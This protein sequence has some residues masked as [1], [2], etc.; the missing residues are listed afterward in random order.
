MQCTLHYPE[1]SYSIAKV[2]QKR[3]D[4]YIS[5]M[6]SVRDESLKKKM[7]QFFREFALIP[8]PIGDSQPCF[9]LAHGSVFKLDILSITQ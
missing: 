8:V 2:T 4:I 3:I 6:T 9:S 7:T 5:F 1:Q